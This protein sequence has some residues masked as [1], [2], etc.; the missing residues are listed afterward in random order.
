MNRLL[1]IFILFTISCTSLMSCGEKEQPIPKRET[2]VLWDFY[3][4]VE[5]YCSPK[6]GVCLEE[7]PDINFH[8]KDNM[9]YNNGLYA[10]DK[11]LNNWADVLIASDINND[12]Y[13]ELFF[14]GENY[15]TPYI[16]ICDFHNNKKYYPFKEITDKCYTYSLD[17]NGELIVI[18]SISRNWDFAIRIG[19][20]SIIDKKLNINWRD[21]AYKN[22][23]SMLYSEIPENTDLNFWITQKASYQDFI[24]KGCSNIPGW[25][26]AY[27]FLDNRYKMEGEY[28][29]SIPSTHVTYLTTG[30]PDTL[31]C[32]TVTRI[33]ITDPKIRVYGFTLETNEEER[34]NILFKEGFKFS[35]KN[36]DFTIYNNGIFSI[37]F[38]ETSIRL[39]V[40]V[41][42]KRQVIY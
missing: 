36:D 24:D 14:A 10:S 37:V 26:G 7:F 21:G 2:I 13:R 38:T 35:S 33:E 18:E 31:D 11:W 39:Q 1:K 42:N 34:S 17:E 28:S 41:T 4:G 16:G 25:F 15:N 8:V 12:G 40:H 20:I 5:D 30:Y 32:N 19:T 27:E 29:C 23:D 6:E 3:D 22:Y 9:T